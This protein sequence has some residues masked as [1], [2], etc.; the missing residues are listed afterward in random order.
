MGLQGTPAQSQPEAKPSPLPN[1][2]L[3]KVEPAAQQN[4]SPDASAQKAPQK[5]FTK[6]QLPQREVDDKTPIITNT[7]LITFNFT[8]TDMYRQTIR[9]H[10]QTVGSASCRSE[11]FDPSCQKLAGPKP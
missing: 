4:P 7:D 9:G 2:E 8:V 10:L 11:V 5:P 1:E 3:L 6:I